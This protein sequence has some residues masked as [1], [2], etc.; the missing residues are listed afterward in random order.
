MAETIEDENVAEV[1]CQLTM[2]EMTS[3]RDKQQPLN[4]GWLA[5]SPPSLLRT[6]VYFLFPS[7][8][9]ALSMARNIITM[10]NEETGVRFGTV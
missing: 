3:F 6:K 5:F 4:R 10:C 8:L 1:T 2:A 7:H 9:P